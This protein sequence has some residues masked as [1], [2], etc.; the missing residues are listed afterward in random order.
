MF[1]PIIPPA[2]NNFPCV[3]FILLDGRIGEHTYIVVYIEVKQWSRLATG[4]GDQ[5]RVKC[6]VLEEDDINAMHAMGSK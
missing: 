3:R 5:E 1:A 2:F 4:L 6:I